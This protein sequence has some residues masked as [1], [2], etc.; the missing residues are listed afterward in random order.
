MSKPP[1]TT[2]YAAAHLEPADLALLDEIQAAVPT[3]YPL[4][5]TSRAMGL[6]VAIRTAAPIVR[7]KLEAAKRAASGAPEEG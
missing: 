4:A 3:L 1:P 5:R 2:V 6:I 7:R